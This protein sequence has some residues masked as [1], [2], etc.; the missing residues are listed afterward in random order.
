MSSLRIIKVQSDDTPLIEQIATIT[1]KEFHHLRPSETLHDRIEKFHQRVAGHAHSP[2]A[3]FAAF[4]EDLLV[5]TISIVEKDLDTTSLH[6]W[7]ASLWVAPRYRHQGIATT[8]LQH[9]E[10]FLR[11]HHVDHTYLFTDSLSDFYRK[12]GWH[13]LEQQECNGYQITIFYKDLRH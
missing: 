3:V 5:G 13:V 9:C 2:L 11:T 7:L 4:Q 6:P 12:L 10:T 8:L 1:Y